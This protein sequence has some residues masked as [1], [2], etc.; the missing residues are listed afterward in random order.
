MRH[1]NVISIS[2]LQGSS[3][4]TQAGVIRPVL[5]GMSRSPGG[6]PGQLKR[7][8]LGSQPYGPYEPYE[9]YGPYEPYEGDLFAS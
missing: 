6:S 2:Q 1:E 4:C 9:P 3:P 7:G 5:R 8:A